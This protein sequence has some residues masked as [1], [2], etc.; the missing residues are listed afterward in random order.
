MKANDLLQT[1]IE[2]TRQ[3]MNQAE[4]LRN[5]DLQTVTWKNDP[6]SWSILECLEHLNLYGDYYLPEIENAIKNSVTKS[7]ET[8]KSGI[9]G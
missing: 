2:Q 6:T 8:F 3:I 4:K 9:L 5:L 1:L 7:E